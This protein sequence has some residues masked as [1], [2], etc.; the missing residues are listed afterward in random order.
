[1]QIIKDGFRGSMP[2]YANR[3]FAA[4]SLRTGPGVQG[5]SEGVNQSQHVAAIRPFPQAG[6]QACLSLG[7]PQRVTI[8]PGDEATRAGLTGPAKC[9]LCR[10]TLIPDDFLRLQ[11]TR[12]R[13]HAC[14][15]VNC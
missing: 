4:G 12:P 9:P 2:T 8:A 6:P 15:R 5:L 7:L 11:C 13:R 10:R 1:M 14:Q 3:P